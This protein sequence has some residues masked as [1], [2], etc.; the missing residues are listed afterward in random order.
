[1]Q[2]EQSRNAND[3]SGNISSIFHTPDL[4]TVIIT[5]PSSSNFWS[6]DFEK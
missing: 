5:P 4:S 6:S 3:S 1:M 2:D